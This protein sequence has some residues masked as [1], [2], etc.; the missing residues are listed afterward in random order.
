MSYE[1][2]VMGCANRIKQL[3]LPFANKVILTIILQSDKEL[4]SDTIQYIPMTNL[5]TV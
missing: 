1:L 2:W 3:I 5:L 4:S